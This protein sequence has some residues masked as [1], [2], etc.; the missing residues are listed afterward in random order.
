MEINII[1]GTSYHSTIGS[2]SKGLSANDFT[3]LG[4]PGKWFKSLSVTGNAQFDFTGSNMGAGA[5][6]IDTAGQTIHL[7][8]GGTIPGTALAVDSIH[9]LSIS[10][11]VSTGGTAYVLFRNFMVR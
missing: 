1:D 9:E 5:I 4:H 7:S 6:I 11:V 3:R 2:G 10:K 8:N